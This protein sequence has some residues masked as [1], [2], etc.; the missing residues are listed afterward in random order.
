[1]AD[2]ITYTLRVHSALNG[3]VSEWNSNNLTMDKTTDRSVHN[4]ISVTTSE[5]ALPTGDVDLTATPALFRY[6]NHGTDP[7][8]IIY[9]RPGTGAENLLYIPPGGEGLTVLTQSDAGAWVI[10]D[11]TTEFEYMLLAL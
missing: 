9:V 3:S 1:M 6:R 7:T 5:A 4:R 2:E 11:A 10:A 8:S